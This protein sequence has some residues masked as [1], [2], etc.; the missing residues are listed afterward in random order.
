MP[1]GRP[2][3]EIDKDE[4]EKLCALQCTKEEISGW[5]DISDDTLERWCKRTYNE[6]FAVVFSK[7][8]EK[9]KISLRR[10][11]FQ[12]AQKNASMAIFLGKNYLQQTDTMRVESHMDGKLHQLIDSLKEPYDIYEEAKSLIGDMA[13]ESAEEN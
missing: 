2:K 5:F 11:Q 9:G 4:F 8:R 12:L 3:K 1:A 6:N 10:A 7:K 13:N